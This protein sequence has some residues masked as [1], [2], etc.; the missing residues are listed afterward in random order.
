M[1]HPARAAKL[2]NA[3]AVLLRLRS[4]SGVVNEAI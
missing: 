4:G 2:A 1:P 3:P